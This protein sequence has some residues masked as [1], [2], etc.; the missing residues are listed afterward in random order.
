[1]VKYLSIISEETTEIEQQVSGKNHCRSVK[2][3][4]N[5]IKQQPL[6]LIRVRSLAQTLL[7]LR[8][9]L[10]ICCVLPLW[11]VSLL[12]SA[13]A[14]LLLLLMTWQLIISVAVLRPTTSHNI[15]PDII[16][17]IL[18]QWLSKVNSLFEFCPYFQFCI[19]AHL[20]HKIQQT[21]AFPITYLILTNSM[22]KLIVI[23]LVHLIKM[24]PYAY[25][26]IP[27]QTVHISYNHNCCVWKLIT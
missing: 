10:T 3:I 12:L 14:N 16:C 5:M 2:C 17:N 19:Q 27:H 13:F 4:R 20:F 6:L 7:Q 15:S 26:F 23:I 1:M 8:P 24:V 9:Y 11:A 25:L 21:P 22:T 18:T